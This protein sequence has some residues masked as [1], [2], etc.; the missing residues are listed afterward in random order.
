MA[1]KMNSSMLVKVSFYLDHIN[2]LN[3]FYIL[4]SFFSILITGLGFPYTLLL[5]YRVWAVGFP[6]SLPKGRMPHVKFNV[7]LLHITFAFIICSVFTII[8]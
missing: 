1:E 3:L 6:I 8:F 2:F 7:C 4:A 5:S